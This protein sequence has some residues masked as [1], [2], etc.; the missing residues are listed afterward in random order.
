MKSAVA[1]LTPD[2]KEF[3]ITFTLHE[4]ERY[5]VGYVEITSQMAQ[6]DPEALNKYLRFS[7]GAGAYNNRDVESTVKALTEAAVL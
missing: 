6:V 1:E 3:C 5:G 4:G 2:Q 7:A